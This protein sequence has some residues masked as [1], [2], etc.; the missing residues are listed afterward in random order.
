MNEFSE[1]IQKT[2]DVNALTEAIL[3]SI[4]RLLD[5]VHITVAL[6]DEEGEIADPADWYARVRQDLA[7]AE[8]EQE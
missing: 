4:P 8:F 2:L 6:L 3:T 1:M 7:G 5:V